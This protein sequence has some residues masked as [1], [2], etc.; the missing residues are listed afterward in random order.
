MKSRLTYI[1]SAWLALAWVTL[2]AC[3]ATPPI[4]GTSPTVTPA[5]L[6]EPYP[7]PSLPTV[8]PE[9][10][11]M[12]SF[13]IQKMETVNGILYVIPYHSNLTIYERIAITPDAAITLLNSGTGEEQ[14]AR[15]ADIVPQSYL[16]VVG[17]HQYIREGNEITEVIFVARKVVIQ[18]AGTA[19]TPPTPRPVLM[20]GDPGYPA[21]VSVPIMPGAATPTQPPRPTPTPCE[22]CGTMRFVG[23]V[24]ARTDDRESETYAKFQA[25]SASEYGYWYIQIG[26]NTAVTFEDWSPATIFDIAE[27]TMIDVVGWVLDKE[28]IR[29]EYLI[30][31]DP[32]THP[33][34]V[35]DPAAPVP[36]E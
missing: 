27:G 7:P 13:V 33:T 30:I 15:L 26:R 5:V 23:V 34:P 31:L 6:L 20:P 2:V 19:A 10:G 32:A 14:R 25:V 16:E 18:E 35:F 24:T 12:A 29:A 8:V 22:N 21:P 3:V 28:N 1:T 11:Y 9:L 36:S 4:P 17:T